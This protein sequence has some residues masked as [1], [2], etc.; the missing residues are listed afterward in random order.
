MLRR[1]CVFR[2]LEALRGELAGDRPSAL[3]SLLVDQVVACHAAERAAQS[4]AATPETL[5]QGSFGVKQLESAQRRLLAAVRALT[6]LREM[7]PAAREPAP[8]LKLFRE[9]REAA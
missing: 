9:S 5:G 3:E 4:Q 1:E 7:A 6:T 8:T 2:E